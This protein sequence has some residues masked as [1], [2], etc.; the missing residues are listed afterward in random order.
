M[1]RTSL[2]RTSLIR[3]SL[4]RTSLIRTS[5]IRTTDYFYLHVLICFHDYES[6]GFIG[7][8]DYCGI[9]HVTVVFANKIEYEIA[10]LIDS[11]PQILFLKLNY[12]NIL[13][14]KIDGM[15]V[16]DCGILQS[17]HSA[18]LCDLINSIMKQNIFCLFCGGE[19]D[20]LPD[21]PSLLHH[22][23]VCPFF[24]SAKSYDI[25]M[26]SFSGGSPST[27]NRTSCFETQWEITIS[28]VGNIS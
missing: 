8:D 26:N 1:D 16:F 13:T 6:W 9:D 23:S 14:E 10:D 2:I 27:F 15:I 22:L 7:G 3:T 12:K 18:Q 20:A 19:F 4:I 25:T 24:C 17:N 28:N 21:I 11:I 5:L